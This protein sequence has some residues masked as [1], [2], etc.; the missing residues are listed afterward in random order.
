[1][2]GWSFYI[3]SSGDNLTS[4]A[5]LSEHMVQRGMRNAF[6]WHEHFRHTCSAERCGIGDRPELARRE[7]IAA[8]GCDLFLGIAR[9]GRGSH[10]E[11]GAALGSGIV[12]RIMLVGVKPEDSVFYCAE[13]V[14]RA[15]YLENALRHLGLT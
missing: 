12:R 3:A 11:L 2:N 4:V 1:M 6:P 5:K 9:L 10:V 15:E 14:E 13:G 8:S 7:L